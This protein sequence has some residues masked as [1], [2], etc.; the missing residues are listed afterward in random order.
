MLLSLNEQEKN[1]WN[2]K[3][4][5]FFCINQSDDQPLNFWELQFASRNNS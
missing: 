1:Q 3:V 5:C 2:I 4:Y